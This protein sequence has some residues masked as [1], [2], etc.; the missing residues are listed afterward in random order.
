VGVLSGP[1]GAMLIATNHGSAPIAAPLRFAGAVF[2]VTCI[3]MPGARFE[4]G[5]D[6]TLQLDAH[7]VGIVTRRSP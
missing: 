7:A 4:H 2:D 6:T 3:P 5:S 1:D